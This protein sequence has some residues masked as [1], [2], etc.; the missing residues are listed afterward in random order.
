MVSGGLKLLR[1]VGLNGVRENRVVVMAIGEGVVVV[2]V[3]TMMVPTGGRTG[4][5]VA[6]WRGHCI[7]FL[8]GSGKEMEDVVFVWKGFKWV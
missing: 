6:G 1:R 4:G 2:V 8:E 7:E 5:V 3:A